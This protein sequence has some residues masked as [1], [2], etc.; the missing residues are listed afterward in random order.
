M[1]EFQMKTWYL[2]NIK[3]TT[4]VLVVLYHV[5][6]I[7]NGVG[8][9]GAILGSQSI[10]IFD[11]LA[12]FVYPWFMVLLYVVAGIDSWY[13]L[14]K[15]TTKQFLKA[16]T[17]KLLIPSTIGL[18]VYQWITGY[19][20]MIAGGAADLIPP[21]LVW[22]I[23]AL[24][25]TG[26]LWF[27]QVLYVYSLL[28]VLFRK[29]DPNERL[30][31]LCGK[32]NLW[33]LFGLVVLVYASSFVFNLPVLTM[34][35]FGIYFVSFMIGYLFLSHERPQDELAAPANL[36]MVLAV[37]CGF[38][39]VWLY[40][41]QDFTTNAIL[42]SIP[43]NL[44]LW[45]MVLA[46]LGFFKKHFNTQTPFNT[47]MNQTSFE[48]YVLHYPILETL[49]YVNVQV[50]HLPAWLRYLAGFVL[51]YPLSLGLY[52]LIIRIP[53]LRLLVLGYQ[54]PRPASPR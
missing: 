51:V 29:L 48:V 32:A 44:Y 26:P 31:T 6:Y 14:Q 53:I 4:V 39:Y 25:G 11:D 33:V 49:C 1:S 13:A 23:A 36:L 2:N 9:P 17:I 50:F 35:R 43:T 41:G 30:R 52:E 5:C 34:Y 21:A 24:S 37:L 22:P 16:R 12:L 20:G 7:F 8:I 47:F 38:G 10:P 46:I 45:L 28:L 27:I 42:Q 18:L 15:K 40:Q 19:V 54:S 3:W